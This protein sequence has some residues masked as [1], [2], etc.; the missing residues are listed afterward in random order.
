[1]PNRT[2][3]NCPTCLKV[4]TTN[5][6]HVYCA[7]CCCMNHLK[8]TSNNDDSVY[9]CRL[10][11]LHIFPYNCLEGNAVFSIATLEN[12]HCRSSL[13]KLCLPDLTFNPFE[14]NDNDKFFYQLDID[15]DLNYFNAVKTN[16]IYD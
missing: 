5:Q 13:I 7:H 11:L 12:L 10:C 8:C 1:M 15:P 9:S 6:Q 16:K 14:E 3:L 4:I 2:K